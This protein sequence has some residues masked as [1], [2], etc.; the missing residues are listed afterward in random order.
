MQETERYLADYHA[1]SDTFDK[2]DLELARRNAA[3][4][5]VA[6][7]G[8]ANAP[9][10]PGPRQSRAQIQELLVAEG[11]R[12]TDEGLRALERVGDRASAAGRNDRGVSSS[13]TAA[14]SPCAWRGPPARWG[15]RPRAC[16]PRPTPGRFTS[17]NVDR[18]V[19]LGPGPPSQT[20]LSIE[21]LL[22]AARESGSDAVH[23]GY[24]FLSENA[25]FARAVGEAG[26]TWV[27]PP[28]AAI[29]AMGDKLRARA[30]MEKA[31]VPVV[32]GSRRERR[33]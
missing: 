18:A 16:T 23:P 10:R 25:D 33:E 19:S 21:R 14:R 12:R 7:L 1:S 22:A 5:A 8:L 13:P 29:E 20:Y 24:G 28:P 15:S 6:V 4:A 26:L 2:V 9:G 32:P 17:G 3:V 11:A 30:A 31:G 27:G